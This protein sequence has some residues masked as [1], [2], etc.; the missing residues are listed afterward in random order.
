MRDCVGYARTADETGDVIAVQQFQAGLM[1]TGP[2]GRFV[3]VLFIDR[4]CFKCADFATY[5][6]FV[7][8][9]R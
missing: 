8:L 3:Y 7:I 6:R 5:E 2:E 9:P 4:S 1:L